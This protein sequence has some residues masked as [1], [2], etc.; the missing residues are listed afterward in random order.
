MQGTLPPRI[1]SNTGPSHPYTTR[2]P[3]MSV[4]I[5]FAS[6]TLALASPGLAQTFEGL[7]PSVQLAGAAG[8]AEA[9]GAWRTSN[10]DN[11]RFRTDFE[12]GYVRFVHGGSTAPFAADLSDAQAADLARVY[13]GEAY[14]L[15][16]M[17]PAH[18][19]VDEVVFLPLGMFGSSDKLTVRFRQVVG[20]VPVEGGAVNVLLDLEGRLLS[21]D[22]V[23]LPD[24]HLPQ[25]LTPTRDA[26]AAAKLAIETFQNDT[27]MEA[28]D[29]EV[30]G[31]EIV[32]EEVG[33]ARK[34]TLAWNV[35]VG[36][37]TPG[38]TPEAFVYG[39]SATGG[40]RVVSE[41][42]A[43]HFF[44][45]S[46]TVSVNATP[47]IA[48]DTPSNPAVPFPGAYMRVTS[49][50]AGVTFTDQNGSY[51]FPGVTGPIDATFSF[52]GTYNDVNNVAGGD[53]SLTTT[54]ADGAGNDVLLNPNQGQ[55]T[56]AQ[57]NIF[58]YINSMRDWTRS[59]NPADSTSDFTAFSNANIGDACN[60]FYDGF[61]TNY[62]NAQGG[63]ANT[64]FSSVIHHEMGHWMNDRYGS[65]NGSDGFGEGNADVFAMYQA[66][67]PIVGDGFSGPGTIVRNGENTRQ[68]CGDANNGC[69]GQVHTDGEVLMGALWKVRKQLNTKYGDV[70]GDLYSNLLFNSWMN[71]YD[72]REI[73]TII[74][75]HWLTLDDDDGNIDNGT[76]NLDVIDGG[77]Q[78]QGFPAFE[79]AFVLVD[80][81]SGPAATLDEIGPYGVEARLQ[82]N[83]GPAVTTAE[84]KFTVDG[85]AP[86][87][88]AMTPA[89]G[90]RYFAVIPGQPSPSKVE[91]WIET[92]TVDG[93]NRF[94]KNGNEGFPV[95]VVAQFFFDGFETGGDNG[96]THQEI[97]K[98]DDWQRG[99]PQGQSGDPSAAFNGNNVWANDLGGEGFNGEYQSD[100]INRLQSPTINL[101]GSSGATLIYERWLT[102]EE[103][104]FDQATIR[105]NDS[106]V[107][108]N[109]LNG[110]L[111]DT[112][113]VTHEVDISSFDGQNVTLEWRLETDGGLEFGGWNLDDVRIETLEPSPTV[114][115]GTLYGS[116]TSG[117]TVPKLDTSGQPSTLGNADFRLTLKDA[118]AETQAFIGLGFAQV[119]VPVLGVQALVDP[120]Y[121]FAGQ[122]NLI[123]QFGVGFP[124]PD[125]IGLVGL[126]GYAQAL[127]V[128]PAGPAGFS[129]TAGLQISVIP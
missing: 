123:G 21:L 118:P 22:T 81:V 108:A 45:V 46:G 93:A 122:T 58:T 128:D 125:S 66:D 40:L 82:A 69:Y 105:V 109:P 110:N 76:P 29:V 51:N 48:A 116:A 32:Q 30:L 97:V 6:A 124:I 49:P 59:V 94:P 72:D 42:T 129:A 61:S 39:I 3:P 36:N 119:S 31:L 11:W 4:R 54:L 87:T 17:D 106:E 1:D 5:L 25:L 14:G 100:V 23:G 57:A 80:Q 52:V 43:I 63:C 74:R 104:I 95:G 37:Q 47:G 34:G 121:L 103:G 2:L 98:Q 12:T 7:S 28:L 19:Q 35:R 99:V 77:F 91:W 90:D 55:L 78:E 50:Q 86:Q 9:Q 120:S 88:V 89:S 117:S 64:A 26:G 112:E 16:G 73:K 44:D 126:T 68:F 113:W 101:N 107:W 83:V 85:G 10:G 15:L 62:F 27:R 13:V 79:L 127:V 33:K 20:G 65:F 41:R 111:L 70:P 115:L 53:Y 24:V 102:V 75:D 18:L 92:A 114:G 96:W 8:L 56:T 71:A 67:S 84:L 60:A 38:M